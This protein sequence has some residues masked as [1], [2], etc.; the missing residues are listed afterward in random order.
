MEDL[1]QEFEIRATPKYPTLSEDAELSEFLPGEK[2]GDVIPESAAWG[3]NPP[4]PTEDVLSTD[5]TAISGKG[6]LAGTALSGLKEGQGGLGLTS[7]KP[8]PV[9]VLDV[10]PSPLR[11]GPSSAGMGIQSGGAGVGDKASSAAVPSAAGHVGSLGKDVAAGT[12]SVAV[13][14]AVAGAAVL[15]GKEPAEPSSDGGRAEATKEPQK[16][17]SFLARMLSKGVSRKVTARAS[18]LALSFPSP[19]RARHV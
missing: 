18:H 12:A 16:K 5:P 11:P 1:L 7:G 6:D 4:P 13:P 17:Q 10:A 2:V 9:S 19:M 15:A 14:L 3:S 8:S